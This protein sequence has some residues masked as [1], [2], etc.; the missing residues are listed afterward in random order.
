MLLRI[1]LAIRECRLE[2]EQEDE[3]ADINF[4]DVN[5]LWKF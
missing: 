2:R 5:K 3:C 4:A 1:I